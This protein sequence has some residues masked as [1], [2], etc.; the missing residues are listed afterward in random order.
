MRETERIGSLKGI[1]E[2]TEQLFNRVGV[3]NVGDIL[4]YYPRGFEIFDDPVPIGSVEEGRVST[5]AGSVFRRIQVS[6]NQRM[7]VTALYLKDLTGTLKVVWF[8]MPF[9][10]N[11]LGKGGVIILRGRVVRK[12]EGLVMEHP[13]I[14]YP[15]IKYE[16]KLH[17]MQPVDPLLQ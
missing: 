3:K 4:R 12:K 10:R 11:T 16:E 9:L 1:G 17:T 14:Y 13:E 2:K 5:V 8:R 6:G 15:A 7:R